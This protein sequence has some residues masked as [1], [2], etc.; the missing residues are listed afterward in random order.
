MLTGIGGTVVGA[1]LVHRLDSGKG[2][3]LSLAGGLT[4]MAGLLVGFGTLA[5]LVFEDTWLAI[6]QEG[7]VL[8]DDD[9]E[10]LVSWDELGEVIVE[11]AGYLVFG[12]AG[13][14][15][16]RW[17]AGGVAADIAARI[18]EARRKAAHGLPVVFAGA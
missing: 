18:A 11:P 6:R 2:A 7:V 4:L 17:Y 3:L 16:V 14:D 9:A 13:A 10:I 8:H 12:R 15:P 1:H 5:K